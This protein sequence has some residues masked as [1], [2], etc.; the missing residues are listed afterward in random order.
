MALMLSDS[1]S[2]F[3][4]ATLP[5]FEKFVVPDLTGTISSYRFPEGVNGAPNAD[6]NEPRHMLGRLPSK[7]GRQDT[8]PSQRPSQVQ[9]FILS[10]AKSPQF[11]PTTRQGPIHFRLSQNPFTLSSSFFNIYNFLS[12]PSL[13]DDKPLHASMWLFATPRQVCTT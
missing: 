5:S 7:E 11:A 4:G 13:G 9:R 10:H 2:E 6:V 8:S 12:K 3:L 1:A